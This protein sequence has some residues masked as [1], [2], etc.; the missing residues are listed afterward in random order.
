LSAQLAIEIETKNKMKTD[1]EKASDELNILKSDKISALENVDLLS[2]QV[3]DLQNETA[4][5][6]GLHERIHQLEKSERENREKLSAMKRKDDE[7]K[8]EVNELLRESATLKR[9]LVACE[10]DR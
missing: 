4:A 8:L 9:E 5:I 10:E 7:W 3:R 6:P 2:E 1:L